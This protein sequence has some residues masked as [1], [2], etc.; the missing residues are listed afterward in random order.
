MKNKSAFF[1]EKVIAG[2]DREDGMV[3]RHCVFHGSQY[4]IGRQLAQ[5]AVERYNYTAK[6]SPDKLMTSVNRDYLEQTWPSHYMRMCGVA[7]VLGLDINDDNYEYSELYYSPGSPSPGCS[8]I[9]YPKT[10][11]G[12]AVLSRNY[13]FSTGVDPIST[14]EPYLMEV[15]PDE[16]YSYLCMSTYDL[17]GAASDGV[18]SEGLSVAL[19]ADVETGLSVVDPEHSGGVY[20]YEGTFDT[21]RGA[22]G[23]TEMQVA[24]YIL[25]TCKD[26]NE[27]KRALLTLLSHYKVIPLHYIVGDRHGN[28]FVFEGAMQGHLPRFIDC[29]NAP[30]PCT[31][32]PVREHQT[33]DHEIVRESVDRLT[34]LREKIGNNKQPISLD[35][36]R[37]VSLSVAAVTPAGVGQYA[38][39]V[40]SRT[41]W[42]GY[43][44]LEELTLTINYYLYDTGPAES[45]EIHR[46]QDLVFQLET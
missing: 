3:V 18:N 20:D 33:V 43:Y 42:H 37:E 27:A 36:I 39:D 41:L 19:L 1:K 5:L 24:R 8:N 23:V 14:K 38:G 35:F 6:P 16:G 4:D 45:P 46:T 22:V 30:L 28:G 25:E 15:Y 10:E 26:A 7:D 34:L 21:G 2:G 17:L 31:N 29:N 12:H 44:D 40:P 32:H 11:H 13:D 9:Y